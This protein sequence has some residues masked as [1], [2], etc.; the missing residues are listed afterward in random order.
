MRDTLRDKAY[1]DEAAEAAW[2]EVEYYWSRIQ[3]PD[4]LQPYNRM[5]VCHMLVRQT[6]ERLE[7]RYCRGDAIADLGDDV[8][9]LLEF[10][11]LQ[12]FYAD[13][14]P[15]EEQDSRIQH[16]EFTFE[17]FMH[18]LWWLSFAV[19]LGRPQDHIRQILALTG[20]EGQDRLFDTLAHRL[21]DTE[22]PIGERLIHSRPYQ[23]LM[24]VIDADEADRPALMVEFMDAWYP[25]VYKRGG[26]RE[27]HTIT[28]N[29]AYRGYWCYEAPLVVKLYGID[30]ASF[31]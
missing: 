8:D 11:K 27:P 4:T 19:C 9:R 5:L 31:R 2:G 18:S 28:E 20:N 21:G 29:D 10:R 22:R 14:L 15:E 30:D 13:A 12:A 6:L 3:Q 24:D 26:L 25:A 23:K 16:E 17:R 1:F 7:Y